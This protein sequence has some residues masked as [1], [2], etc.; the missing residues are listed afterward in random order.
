MLCGD[1]A[2][3]CHFGEKFRT[4]GPGTLQFLE[5]WRGAKDATS[6]AANEFNH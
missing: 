4:F 1:A 3:M 6:D 5:P 2:Q